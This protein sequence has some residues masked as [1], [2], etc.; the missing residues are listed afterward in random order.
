[1]SLQL[2]KDPFINRHEILLP[3]TP[4]FF[5]RNRE[6]LRELFDLYDLP[7]AM[8]IEEAVEFTQPWAQGDHFTPK[9][10]VEI[11][12]EIY[13]KS[14]KLYETMGL[15]QEK[16]PPSG[17]YDEIIVLGALQR[18]N[19]VRTEF[20]SELLL[21][22]DV[23]LS[24][25]A[26]VSLW[27]G[28]RPL[29]QAKEAQ[30]TRDQIAVLQHASHLPQRL[31]KIAN[32]D[33]IS[34]L[35]EADLLLLSTHSLF[36]SLEQAE[37]S[38]TTKKDLDSSRFERYQSGDLTVE[39]MDAPPVD[40]PQGKPRHTTESCA[41]E[42]L[43]HR[44]PEYGSR[45]LFISSNPYIQRTN[46]AFERVIANNG[47]NDIEVISAGPGAYLDASNHVFL[48]EIARNLYED[49]LDKQAN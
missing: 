14:R 30:F 16:M 32:I 3:N 15:V 12:D 39:L 34:R 6:N 48:G 41:E 43:E 4:T 24:E 13:A 21:H 35:T 22:S 40:R 38:I 37:N 19:N 46:R 26:L 49:L 44:Q 45:V 27:G 2:E 42:W 11:N 10:Q 18:A 29:V 31:Q 33:D 17:V 23:S 36:G 20:T 7:D 47:R 1:M 28:Q 8:T 5:E 9:Q 25:N